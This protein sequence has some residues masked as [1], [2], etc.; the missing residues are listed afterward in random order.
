MFINCSN[1]HS[2]NWGPEQIREAEKWGKIIDY[3]FPAVDADAD[4]AGVAQLAD[5]TMKIILEMK[6]KA[7]MCQGEFTLTY[8][9]VSRLKEKGIPA[10]AACSERKAVEKKLPNGEV[11]KT[12]I[13]EFKRFRRY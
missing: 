3:T 5:E 10:L 1:H 6:P 2:S 7:V 9:L 13:F 4:E 12:S 11:E 8:A